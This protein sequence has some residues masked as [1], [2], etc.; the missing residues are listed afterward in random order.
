MSTNG[1][2]C[3]P[4]PRVRSIT[5]RMNWLH[6]ICVSEGFNTEMLQVANKMC[7]QETEREGGRKEGHGGRAAEMTRAEQHKKTCLQASLAVSKNRRAGR[8]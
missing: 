6:L 7:N 1:P 4:S 2:W 3:Y 8:L 5:W